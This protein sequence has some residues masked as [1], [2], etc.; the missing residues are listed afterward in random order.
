M[1]KGRKRDIGKRAT[2]P[3]GRAI[4]QQEVA[5]TLSSPCPPA[6]WA[7]YRD[8][9]QTHRAGG[10][11]AGKGCGRSVVFLRPVQ[12][13]PASRSPGPSF[14]VA[15]GPRSPRRGFGIQHKSRTAAAKSDAGRRLFPRPSIAPSVHMASCHTYRCQ[16]GRSESQG[17]GP[18]NRPPFSKLQTPDPRGRL[19]LVVATVAVRGP[20]PLVPGLSMPLG[21]TLHATPP[22]PPEGVRGMRFR[23]DRCPEVVLRRNSPLQFGPSEDQCYITLIR[24][25][26]TLAMRRGITTTTSKGEVLENE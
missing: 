14:P 6:H 24:P 9:H 1:E 25:R 4:P 18:G 10:S 7:P 23:R 22:L 17:V 26:Q 5:R 13:S 12:E 21:K 19:P 20:P 2:C 11:A 8:R 16:N 3:R 15:P